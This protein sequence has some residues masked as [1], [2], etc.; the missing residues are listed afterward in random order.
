[1][2]QTQVNKELEKQRKKYEEEKKWLLKI[3]VQKNNELNWIKAEFY[4]IMNELEKLRSNK[5]K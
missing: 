1:V 4:G 2:N 5:F 3:I